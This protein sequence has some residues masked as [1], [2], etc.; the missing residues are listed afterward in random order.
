MSSPPEAVGWLERILAM[1]GLIEMLLIHAAV[2][3][4]C[5]WELRQLKRL[6]DRDR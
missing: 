1:R 2:V 6:S 5:L 3:A 4:W